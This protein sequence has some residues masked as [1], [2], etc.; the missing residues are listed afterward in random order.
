MGLLSF[1]S[2]AFINNVRKTMWEGDLI[3]PI[4]GLLCPLVAYKIDINLSFSLMPSIEDKTLMKKEWLAGVNH[5][6]K[7]KSACY[8]RNYQET[9]HRK[10][11]HK[12]KE[13][14]LATY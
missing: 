9:G 6:M 11:V 3:Y 7:K 4:V 8:P 12:L 5:L 2:M 1:S 13:N 14:S 10:V